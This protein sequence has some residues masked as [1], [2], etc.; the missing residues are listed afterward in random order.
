MRK[1]GGRRLT[2]KRRF[3]REYSERRAV[4]VLVVEPSD[5][6]LNRGGEGLILLPVSQDIR[7]F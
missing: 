5:R 2:K 3:L 6:K 7:D 1:S 4:A